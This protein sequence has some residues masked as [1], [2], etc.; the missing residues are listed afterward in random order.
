MTTD[1]PSPRGVTAREFFGRRLK[2]ASMHDAHLAT[3]LSYSTVHRSSRG[4]VIALDTAKALESWSRGNAAAREAGLFISAAATVGL[5]GAPAEVTVDRS[6]EFT[7]EQP[8][9]EV[10]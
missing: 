2:G 8:A 4:E 9:A 5:E 1:T 3:R 10:A 6:A 7:Q